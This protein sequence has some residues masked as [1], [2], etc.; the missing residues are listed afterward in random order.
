[1]AEVPRA[2]SETCWPDDAPPTLSPACTPGVMLMICQGSR[3][4]GIFSRTSAL[5]VAPVA[6][7]FVSTTGDA[8]EMVTSSDICP[9][10]ILWSTPALNPVAI[11]TFGR[12]AFLK[13]A[14][15]NVTVNV[16]IGTLG[17]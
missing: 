14:S 9:I 3:A 7:F 4:D 16:P 15:S 10:S 1:M 2:A 12:C 11:T 5:N 13:L 17:N 8:A 6:V